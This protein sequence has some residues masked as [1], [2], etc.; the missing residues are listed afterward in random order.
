MKWCLTEMTVGVVRN[1][2]KASNV[3]MKEADSRDRRLGW[4]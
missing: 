3:G 2:E 1:V 4:K